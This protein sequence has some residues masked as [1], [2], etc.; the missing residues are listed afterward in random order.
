MDFGLSDEERAIR[1]TVRDF[2]AKELMPLEAEVLR[3]ERNHQ[4]GSSRSELRELQLKAKSFGFW[5][6]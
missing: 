6:L 5:G 1:D 2:M 3:R 4:P